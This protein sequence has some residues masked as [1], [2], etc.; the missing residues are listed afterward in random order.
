MAFRFRLHLILVAVFAVCAHAWAADPPASTE[1][2]DETD[3]TIDVQDGVPPP[4]AAAPK[5]GRRSISMTCAAL[6]Q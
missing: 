5:A 3:S 1:P 2:V 6:R 4:A